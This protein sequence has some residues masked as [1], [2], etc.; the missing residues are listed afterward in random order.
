MTGSELGNRVGCRLPSKDSSKVSVT[1]QV[2]NSFQESNGHELSHKSLSHDFSLEKTS[3]HARGQEEVLLL[4]L[5]SLNCPTHKN[6]R[7]KGHVSIQSGK[8]TANDL[9]TVTQ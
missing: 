1:L 9:S 5:P 6:L 8:L 4:L 3:L 2:E 7:V